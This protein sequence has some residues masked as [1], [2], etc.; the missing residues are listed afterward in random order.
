[1]DGEISYLNTDLDLTSADDLTELGA[2]LE[3][4]GVPPMH[5]TQ[6]EDRLWY[7]CFETD[8]QHAEPESNIAAMLAVV[9]RAGR[10]RPG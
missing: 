2:A 4:A 3:A 6:R 5:V 8:E 10:P 7:A 9:G 1:M